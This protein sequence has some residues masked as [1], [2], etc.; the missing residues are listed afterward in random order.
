M[1]YYIFLFNAFIFLFSF[2]IKAQNSGNL[3][4]TNRINSMGNNRPNQIMTI[5]KDYSDVK[6]KGSPYLNE[7]YVK[8]TVYINGNPNNEAF[9]RYNAHL[10]FIEVKEGNQVYQLF[11]RPNIWVEMNGKKLGI[12][13]YLENG[14]SKS[15]YLF[16][17]AEGAMSFYKKPARRLIDG[18]EPKSGYDQYI[19]PRYVDDHRYYLQMNDGP[20]TEVKVNNRFVKELFGAD[21]KKVT[22]YAKTQDLDP[23]NPEELAALIDWYNSL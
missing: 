4:E 15:G 10:D 2:G 13:E 20:I 3:V 23:K 19:P 6:A 22:E 17:L 12:L 14:E 1:K 18:K 21:Y 7:A 9:I 11:R 5:K 16:P 8:G